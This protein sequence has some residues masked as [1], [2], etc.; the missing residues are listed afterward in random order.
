MLPKR[1]TESVVCWSSA[2]SSQWHTAGCDGLPSACDRFVN[3]CRKFRRSRAVCPR[4]QRCRAV[5]MVLWD[6]SA[7]TWLGNTLCTFV[8]PLRWG[9]GV[10]AGGGGNALHTHQQDGFIQSPQLARATVMIA[11]SFPPTVIWGQLVNSKQRVSDLSRWSC[12]RTV[13]LNHGTFSALKISKKKIS[14]AYHWPKCC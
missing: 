11:G 14:K 10:C 4:L 2:T 1:G 6:C 5:D 12:C 13:F 9:R 3:C 7:A 8:G